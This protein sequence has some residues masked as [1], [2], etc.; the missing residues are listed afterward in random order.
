MAKLTVNEKTYRI[1]FRHIS[2]LGKRSQLHR[3][4]VQAVT[5]CVVI[6]DDFIAI[7]NALCVDGDTFSR[8]VGRL[9][10]LLKLLD[11]CGPLRAIK[12]DFVNAYVE[13][14]DPQPVPP[15]PRPQVII[16]SER[17]AELKAAGQ[18]GKVERRL[19]RKNARTRSA[20]R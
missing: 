5:T 2:K 9:R 10:S 8:R 16:S 20:S 6:A 14:L 15:E 1:E 4:S 11:H 12:T 13:N 18:A 19:D 3:G 17:K 7:D